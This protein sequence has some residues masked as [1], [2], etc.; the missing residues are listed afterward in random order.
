MFGF[1]KKKDNK[2]VSKD[3]VRNSQTKPSQKEEITLTLQDVTLLADSIFSQNARAGMFVAQCAGF[4]LLKLDENNFAEYWHLVLTADPDNYT[5][6]NKSKAAENEVRVWIQGI[7]EGTQELRRF[8]IHS[9]K[10][11][12]MEIRKAIRAKD[13][14]LDTFEELGINNVADSLLEVAMKKRRYDLE[15]IIVELKDREEYIRKI[16]LPLQRNRVNKYGDIDL[17]DEINELD[18]FID[19]FFDRETFDY[20]YTVSPSAILLDYIDDMLSAS[21]VDEP[22]PLDGIAFE[23]W[24]ASQI[25]AQGWSVAVSKATGDQGIDVLAEHGDVR[26][27]IQCKRYS[28]PIGN[29]AVQEAFTGAQD[30][31][32]GHSCVIGTGGFTPS[33]RSIA[34][35]TGVQLIDADDIG[36]FSSLFGVEPLNLDGSLD[37]GVEDIDEEPP[38]HFAFSGAGA[39]LIG[40]LLRSHI[41]TAGEDLELIDLSVGSSLLEAL[42]DNT[43]EGAFYLPRNQLAMLLVLGASGLKSSVTLN[44]FNVK[45]LL[46]SPFYDA[47]TV[48][49]NAGRTVVFEELVEKSILQ[50]AY[51]FLLNSL[52]Q[53]GPIY[54]A[55][56]REKVSDILAR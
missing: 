38:L 47:D 11:R 26:V 55:A 48:R 4:P 43:G 35:K 39:G 18:E 23:H 19:H 17:A 27:A 28:N 30:V 45:A 3:N 51:K 52:G 53:L 33:A 1:F 46:D 21:K 36:S 25:E 16:F 40:S 22:I 20:F 5:E 56:F 12:V 8:P 13:I 31:D 54:E 37:E 9:D 34:A 49:Q 29:K 32:A 24:C 42:D 6:E 14:T 41:K 44:D 10:D 7:I 15:R 2:N 50:D